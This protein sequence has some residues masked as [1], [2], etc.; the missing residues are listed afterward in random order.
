MKL[1]RGS[2]HDNAKD[3]VMVRKTVEHVRPSDFSIA[4]LRNTFPAC[5][6]G[7]DELTGLV[8]NATL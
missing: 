4:K 8:T 5:F 2:N 1:S 7:G 3:C 6:R